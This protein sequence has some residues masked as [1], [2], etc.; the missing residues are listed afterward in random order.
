VK[1]IQAT[2]GLAGIALTVIG[3]ALYWWGT[4]V[5]EDGSGYYVG[6][7]LTGAGPVIAALGVALA[8]VGLIGVLIGRR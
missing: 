2:L 5:A 4:S 6:T 1:N 8:V 7:F 3:A